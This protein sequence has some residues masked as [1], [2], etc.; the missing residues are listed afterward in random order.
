[1]KNFLEFLSDK[2]RDTLLRHAERQLHRPGAVILAEGTRSQALYFIRAGTVR[3]ERQFGPQT[4]ELARLGERDVFGDMSFVDGEP[5]SATVV[6]D[7]E[8]QTDRVSALALK[9]IIKKDVLFYGRFYHALART[10][11]WRLRTATK[12]PSPT[13]SGKWD[14]L[15]E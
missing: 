2:D 11:S 3:I 15:D 10:L 14:T 9:D 7:T 6:A 5:A 4:I 13:P 12:P 1:M 8:V